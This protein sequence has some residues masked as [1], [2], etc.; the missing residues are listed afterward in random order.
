MAW[1]KLLVV[2]EDSNKLSLT[3]RIKFV[4]LSP[5]W[6]WHLR[7]RGSYL[8]VSLQ[9]GGP[10]LKGSAEAGGSSARRIPQQV[11]CLRRASAE[12]LRL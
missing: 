3:L 10:S 9:C 12:G 6:Q 2:Q 8:G 1:H 4:S 5:V 7:V 11:L